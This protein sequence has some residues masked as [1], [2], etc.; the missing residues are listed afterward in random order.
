M[1]NDE[2]VAFNC[3]TDKKQTKATKKGKKSPPVF[4]S[5]FEIYSLWRHD[6]RHN[7]IKH[8]ITYHFGKNGLWIIAIVILIVV[9]MLSVLFNIFSLSANVLSFIMLNNSMLSECCAEC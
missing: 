6:T 8:N 7:D 5:L 1:A 9:S 3:L 2:E 4:F